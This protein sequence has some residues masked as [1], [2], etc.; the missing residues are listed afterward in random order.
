MLFSQIQNIIHN[1]NQTITYINDITQC[2]PE[3]N[4]ILLLSYLGIDNVEKSPNGIYDDGLVTPKSHC[5]YLLK[6]SW[7]SFFSG[8][9]ALYKGH[10]ELSP[11]PLGVWLTSI[12]YWWK[13][14]YSWRRYL[15]ITFVCIALIYQLYKAKNY[16]NAIGYYIFTILSCVL[17]PIGV[18]YAKTSPALSTFYHGMIHIFGNVANIILYLSNREPICNTTV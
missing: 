9:F 4:F 16:E 12:N 11:V 7:L 8:I 14:D 3:N 2:L 6:I 1:C 15:D 13:P 17:F 18:Y 10:Y 5:N